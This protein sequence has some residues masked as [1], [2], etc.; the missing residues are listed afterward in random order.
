MNH[1]F[2]S[3]A[4]IL[5][6]FL[7][8]ASLLIGMFFLIS[9]ITIFI[10]GETNTGLIVGG[11]FGLFPTSVGI[12]L[13]NWAFKEA[14]KHDEQILAKFIIKTAIAQHGKI[15]PTEVALASDFSIEEVKQELDLLYTQGLFDLQLSEE[16][17]TVYHY[18]E[19]LSIESKKN[20]QDIL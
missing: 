5:R 8:F 17:I 12:W 14:N 4:N 19:M 10:K 16:G 3:F 20:A 15:T 18:K 2:F 13:L 7:G 1:L 6:L 11:L 9:G